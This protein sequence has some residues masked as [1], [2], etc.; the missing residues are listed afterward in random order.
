MLNA[1][2]ELFTRNGTV[3]SLV[4]ADI[5]HF[6]SINDTYGH[7]GGD[8]VL[9]EVA[10]LLKSRLRKYDV[11]SRWGGEEFLFMFPGI[12][13]SAA[14]IVAEDIR[15]TLELH[16][17]VFNEKSIYVTMTFGVAMH[18]ENTSIDGTIKLAD[19]ALYQGKKD[20]RN[21]VVVNE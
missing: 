5:D 10:R 11:V 8:Y 3:F 13:A 16:K 14:A 20:G 6:K 2:H 21:R 9:K 7:D 17:F 1:Q 12:D 4:L 15:K 18:R 19:D